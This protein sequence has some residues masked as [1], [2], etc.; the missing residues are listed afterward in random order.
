MGCTSSR[1]FSVSSEPSTKG[2]ASPS[3]E[4]ESER[5]DMVVTRL[6]SALESSLLPM[7]T[8][9]FV[10]NYE[11]KPLTITLLT[12]N[13]T[14]LLLYIGGFDRNKKNDYKILRELLI[15]AALLGAKKVLEE[16]KYFD[17]TVD[18]FVLHMALWSGDFED[19]ELD[20]F[21]RKVSPSDESIP[22]AVLSANPNVLAQVFA[23]N[24]KL[25]PTVK[26]MDLI[27][28]TKMPVEKKNR[29]L[30]ILKDKGLRTSM[31]F[32]PNVSVEP[33]SSFFA[34]LGI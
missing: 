29:M 23:Q 5:R 12:D 32:A 7:D 8:L 6:K 30:Q 18:S 4:E 27:S 2:N 21:M 9:L 33:D 34:G 20:Y 13:S 22:Y 25:K 19:R 14:A 26:H 11:N 3:F 17:I 28:E 24:T 15:L 31:V 16:L 1:F 10:K